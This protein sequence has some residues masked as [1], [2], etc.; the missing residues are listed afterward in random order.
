MLLFPAYPGIYSRHEQINL[1]SPPLRQ[2]P[3]H[4]ASD[5][6][7]GFHQVGR[8]V[9]ITSINIRSN[10]GKSSTTDVERERYQTVELVLG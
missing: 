5:M 7:K 4:N 1:N 3:T 8:S 10:I 2:S 6:V 9:Q